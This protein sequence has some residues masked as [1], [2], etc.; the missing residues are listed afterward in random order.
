MKILYRISDGGYK[1][2]KPSYVTKR[3]CFTH[4]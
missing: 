4:F 2:N 1:K 3:D